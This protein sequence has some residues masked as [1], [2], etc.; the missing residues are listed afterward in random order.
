MA[1]T[2]AATFSASPWASCSPSAWITLATPAIC[3]AALAAPAALWPATSTWTSL[4]QAMAAVTVLKVAPLMVALSCSAM[5]RAVM[6]DHLGFGLEFLD[7]RRHVGHL[8]AGAALGRLHDLQG[9]Q[10]RLD[11]DAQVLGLQGVELLLLGLHDV[12]QR[13]VARLVQ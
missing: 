13:H 8:H 3:E 7:Q 5:T 12:R 9:L 11:V 2:C 6:S 1:S 10:A 4:P